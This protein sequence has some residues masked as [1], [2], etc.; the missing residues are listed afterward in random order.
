MPALCNPDLLRQS[1]DEQL[2]EQLEEELARHLAECTSCRAELER[3]AADQPEWTQ[4]SAALQREADSASA[5]TRRG[6]DWEFE[7]D[8]AES[9]AD[10]AVD[11]L[12]PSAVAGAIG[13]LGDIDILETIGR[14][15]M[16]IV[17]K[18]N[19]PE[20][21][22]LVA[23][24]VMGPHL[25]SSGAARKRFAREAQ[26]AA[27]ILH[28]NVMPILTVH[29]GG[30]LPYL[31]MPFIACDSL[32]QRI[33]R[34]GPLELVDILRIGMQTASAL[35]SAHGQGLVHRD[36]KPANILLEKGVDRVIL[37]DFGLAR[38]VDDASITRSGII[39]GTPQFMSP[40]QARG[41]ALDARSD[42]F[43][44]GSVLYTMAAGR[45]PFRAESTF[46]I[47]RRITD[48][49]PR[50]IR[51]VNSSVPI[52]LEVIVGK[53]L[54]KQPADRFASAEELA[55]VLEQC[56]A[57]VR[58][59]TSVELP[60]AVVALLP[61]AQRPKEQ[62]ASESAPRR[63]KSA[64]WIGVLS[65]GL[66]TGI[67]AF[68]ALRPPVDESKDNLHSDT[69]AAVA[70]SRSPEVPTPSD[71]D[72]WDDDALRLEELQ[73]DGEQFDRRATRDWDTP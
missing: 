47:L 38:A 29:S 30:K 62:L 53:L 70:G 44:L 21:K 36:V 3:L 46:G 18:G 63:R 48:S 34:S 55:S 66:A 71:A 61:R 33:A 73:R 32:Q 6:P 35:A 23:V 65:A 50:A 31:V 20:L 40:E 58:Q 2:P 41:E 39:A 28:P 14:G 69:G 13:R 68:I 57:H 8:E 60:A 42:L 5:L 22:R 4:V 51:E 59:P 9:A 25:A 24:K 7:H 45:P 19:Q 56:L 11:F 43:S 67:A 54:A 16:G 26:A 64:I 72:S 49:V 17:L 37:T 10:F 27:A 15:G 1:L 12:E 52:W